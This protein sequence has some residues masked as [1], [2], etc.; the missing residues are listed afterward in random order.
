MKTKKEL[1]KRYKKLA[2]E[3]REVL[4][5]HNGLDPYYYDFEEFHATWRAYL[6]LRDKLYTIK[7]QFKEAWF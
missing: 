6:E 7:L 2:K 5:R 3:C 1:L 4:E